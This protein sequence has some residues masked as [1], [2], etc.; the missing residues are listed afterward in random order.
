[1]NKIEHFSK[2]LTSYFLKY[3]FPGRAGFGLASS[4]RWFSFQNG[5]IPSP[6]LFKTSLLVPGS[7]DIAFYIPFGYDN[8]TQNRPFP[9]KIDDVAEDLVL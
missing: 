5:G 6:Y 8:P 4:I 2:V 3:H 7:I 9:K 1:L